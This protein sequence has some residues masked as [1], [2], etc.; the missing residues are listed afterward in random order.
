M[1]TKRYPTLNSAPSLRVASEVADQEC[2]CKPDLP[3]GRSFP[4]CLP[5]KMR[6][7]FERYEE[8]LRISVLDLEP[9]EDDIPFLF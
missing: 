3:D 2:E 7:D 9:S 5:C 1:E 4:M 6:Q 8:D